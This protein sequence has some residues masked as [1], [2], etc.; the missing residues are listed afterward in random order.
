MEAFEDSDVDV[1]LSAMAGQGS[2]EVLEFLDPRVF[3]SNPKPF[4]R[5]CD[6]GYINDFLATRCALTSQYGCTF[7]FEFGNLCRSNTRLGGSPALF[8][9][10]KGAVV[11]GLRGADQD[12]LSADVPR[13]RPGRPGVPGRP[14]EGCR[15]ARAPA[16]ERCAAA[17]MPA[18]YG[19]DDEGRRPGLNRMAARDVFLMDRYL[20]WPL[21]GALT[22]VQPALDTGRF[23][24][25]T[26]EGVMRTHVKILVITGTAGADLPRS[27]A[28]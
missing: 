14:G 8:A 28:R 18:G 4:I 10:M 1:V 21:P 26:G 12:H 19:R 25:A 20:R 24:A 3:I 13:A 17:E 2:A 15:A 7:L 23:H 11:V 6:N 27:P 16:R 22:A 5:F 9:D